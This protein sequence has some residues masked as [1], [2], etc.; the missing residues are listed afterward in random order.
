[1]TAQLLEVNPVL[2]DEKLT[3]KV[4]AE[5]KYKQVLEEIRCYE[6]WSL[7]LREEFVSFYIVFEHWLSELTFGYL[8]KV[9][10]YDRRVTERKK[11]SFDMYIKI[12]SRLG[13]GRKYWLSCF[14]SEAI[15]RL[16]RYFL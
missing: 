12:L 10:D 15:E 9:E 7:E 11:L 6:Q 1:M 14:I 5:N 16:M 3:F 4:F 13:D 2:R 8:P